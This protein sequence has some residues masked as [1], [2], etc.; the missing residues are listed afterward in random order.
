MVA[1]IAQA[2]LTNTLPGGACKSCDTG[3]IKRGQMFCRAGAPLNGSDAAA[4]FTR[5]LL[6]A[7]RSR[8]I[9]GSATAGLSGDYGRGAGL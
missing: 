4:E 7:V 2:A 6:P 3:A 8:L 1:H 5:G 9:G